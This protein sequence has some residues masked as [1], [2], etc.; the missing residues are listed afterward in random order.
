MGD[1]SWRGIANC[2]SR[3]PGWSGTVI[4]SRSCPRLT[5]GPCKSEP[6]TCLKVRI[7]DIGAQEGWGV[8]KWRAA[9][10]V[11][12]GRAVRARDDSLRAREDVAQLAEPADRL[13]YEVHFL[14]VAIQHV[15]RLAQF[16]KE[17]RPSDAEL[18]SAV[19]RFLQRVP[20]AK[21]LRDY[22]THFDDY[23]SG[24][25]QL[26]APQRRRRRTVE[27]PAL[28]PEAP[29]LFHDVGDTK[30]VVSIGAVQVDVLDAPRAAV[31]LAREVVSA[32]ERDTAAFLRPR[33]R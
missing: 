33:H 13:D 19:D 6:G 25:G 29:S 18:V 8:E 27:G 15:L 20:H 28:V 23:L 31:D 32:W 1:R 3:G 21:R 11:Q 14:V 4:A 24:K 17:R 10:E 22:L 30:I 26:Q 12:L 16:A 9:I 5:G 2:K 7:E